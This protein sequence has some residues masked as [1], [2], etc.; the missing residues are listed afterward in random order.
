MCIEIIYI[1]FLNLHSD[2]HIISEEVVNFS[3]SA[4]FLCYQA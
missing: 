4:H 1:V 2:L 3:Y